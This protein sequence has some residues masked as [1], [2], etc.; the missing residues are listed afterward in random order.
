M[1]KYPNIDPTAFNIGPFSIKW[2]GICY[3]IAF[4]L[5]YWLALVKKPDNYTKTQVED[6]LFY[7]VMGVIFGGRVGYILLYY[8]DY[9]FTNPIDVIKFWLPGRSFHG[10]LVGVLIAIKLY[11]R[12]YQQPF[13]AITDFIAPIVPIGILFGRLGNFING[14]LY[15]RVTNVP[16]GMVFE[17]ID[18][19]PRHPSQLYELL[20]EGVLLFII[21]NKFIKTNKNIVGY[22]SAV[23]LIFYGLF[24]ILVEN[25]REPDLDLGFIAH[26]FTMGQ[27][28]SIPML[29][30][31]LY[32]YVRINYTQKN[33]KK[34]KVCNN[35]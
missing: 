19:M 8:P 18:H 22:N 20:L 16:W 27:I 33:M 2:Y 15:G 17:H 21:L 34:D 10:G 14:E 3:L 25:Y 11:I 4:L 29:V 24:R 9:I 1:L 5:C 12:K 6:L 28:L 32:W 31:G 35:I 7:I 13:L 23:F 26:H 30:A